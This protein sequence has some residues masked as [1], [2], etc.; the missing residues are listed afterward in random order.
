MMNKSLLV[1]LF[2][3]IFCISSVAQPTLQWEKAYPGVWK[4][5]VGKPEKLT[6]LSAAE[7]HPNIP[8]L[9]KLPVTDFPLSKADISY[10]IIDHKVYLRFPLTREEKLYGLGLNFQTVN[11]RGRI[12]NLHV[13]HFGG[14]DNGRNHAPVPFYVS[15]NGYGVLI[16]AAR[17]ITVYAGTAV[18][19]DTKNPPELM[20]RNTNKKWK[21]QPYSDAVEILVP[22]DGVTMYVF[23]GPT[24][25]QAVQRY[26]LMNGG[27]YIP[28]KWGLGFTQRVPTLYTQEDILLEVQQFKEHQFPLDF[29]GVEPGWQSMA[30]PCTFEWDSTRFPQPK[31]FIDT[32]S[33]MG[34][35]ANLWLNPYVSPKGSLYTKV[36]NY[37]GSHTVW[38]G[39]VPDLTL[40]KVRE[41]YTQHFAKNHLDLG[42]SGYKIDETDGF[43][44]WVWPDVATFPSGT[45]AEQMRQTFG[46]MMQQMSASW[47]KDRNQRTYGLTR[48]SNAGAS[49]LPYVIYNDYYNHRDFITALINSSFIGILWTPEVRASQNA[50][51]W[52][53]RIQTVCFSPMAMLNAWADGTKPWSFPEVET[54]VRDVAQLRMQLLPYLY[55][56]FAQYHFEGKPPF[57]AMNLVDGFGFQPAD[58]NGNLSS[59][60]NPYAIATKKDCKDQYMVG[61]NILVAPFFAGEKSRKVFLPQ[62]KWYD[63]Y[64]GDFVGENQIIEIPSTL[65]KIPLFVK[66]GGIIPLTTVHNQAPKPGEQLPLELR[67]YGKSTGTFT[68]YDDDGTTFNYEKGNYSLNRFNVVI[69]AK[70][71][72][73][74]NITNIKPG[75]YNYSTVQW[76]FMTK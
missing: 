63:F 37:A 75:P 61:D 12:L 66:D 3:V 34:I 76:R 15:S 71:A 35:K 55:T 11:Q 57:R 20:D 39:L 6:L 60:N 50:E 62:G 18:R 7:I 51:E 24:P 44:N 1:C 47:F 4:A 54:A 40:K 10:T 49:Y 46:L 33:A 30:Y 26:N 8:A 29:I 67:V 45:S 48:A 38:N 74:G 65:E 68:L 14:V 59:T 9:E 27:G 70:G 16:D 72:L 43:D 21:A 22:A 36:K 64:T 58:V 23:A 32:L 25:M 73:E 56:T 69:N 42:V 2:I 13:D 28:P 53:R 52:V 19:R 5:S 31:K 41:A 17:Y